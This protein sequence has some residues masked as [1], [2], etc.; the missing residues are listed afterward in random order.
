MGRPS[1]R[2]RRNEM[3]QGRGDASGQGGTACA[4]ALWWVG[5]MLNAQNAQ[6]AKGWEVWPEVAWAGGQDLRFADCWAGLR[7]TSPHQKI[8]PIGTLQQKVL[9]NTQLSSNKRKGQS[10]VLKITRETRAKTI[11]KVAQRHKHWMW[12]QT[13]LA[14]G[15][16]TVRGREVR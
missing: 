7:E 6:A 12:V 3:G 13:T 4:K 8:E 5:N 1:L 14:W 2:I 16:N 15:F 9:F 10:Q 11:S